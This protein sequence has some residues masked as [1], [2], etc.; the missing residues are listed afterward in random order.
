M[1]KRNRGGLLGF[2]LIPIGKRSGP[3]GLGVLGEGGH[4][5][6]ALRGK[7]AGELARE[8]VADAAET[9][10]GSLTKRLARRVLNLEK[11]R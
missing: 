11:G 3:L 4:A 2:G 6:R 9:F 10:S 8:A 5:Q 7:R 1:P